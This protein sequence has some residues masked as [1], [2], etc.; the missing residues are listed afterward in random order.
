[1]R[2]DGKRI[3]AFMENRNWGHTRADLE[4]EVKRLRGRVTELEAD[5]KRA[6]A[7]PY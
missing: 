3:I 2:Q 1:M 5:L 4:V 7:K 6:R